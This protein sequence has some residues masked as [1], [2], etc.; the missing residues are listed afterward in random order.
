LLER[1]AE[2]GVPSL[3][4]RLS[5]EIDPLA[6]LRLMRL[7]RRER[8]QVLHLH[9]G[10]AVLHG[11]LAGRALSRKACR[12]VAHRRTVF[13][14]KGR[15]KYAGRIDR[16]IAISGAVSEQLRAAGVPAEKIRVVYSGVPAEVP[17]DTAKGRREWRK[18]LGI[19]DGEILIAHAAALS[20]EKRQGDLVAAACEANILLKE[21][22]GPR[23]HLAL[24]GSGSEEQ[25]LREDIA[26]RH[27][28]DTVHFTG[29]LKDVSPLWTAAD[30]AVYA[31]EAE[32][33]CTALVQAQGA[34]LPAVITRAGG[35]TEVVA[36]GETGFVVET[37]DIQGLAR[38]IAELAQDKSLRA[39]MGKASAARAQKTF[40][41]DQMV[42]G[43]LQVYRE[44]LAQS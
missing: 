10:H 16:I 7:L 18:K 37:G 24:A 25:T 14:L 19:A 29:F 28:G 44:L 21:R 22:G 27:A 17:P 20:K 3:G 6:T 1:C 43:V 11:Q 12:V 42:D 39:R 40:S 2:A 31:S 33:L 8:P 13:K 35:M 36:D 41:A 32:G 34:G 30:L 38:R 26:R 5:G 15:W 4:M 9:D 23:V